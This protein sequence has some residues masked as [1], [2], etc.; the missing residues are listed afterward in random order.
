MDTPWI[1]EVTAMSKQL[2]PKRFTRYTNPVIIEHIASQYVLGTLSTRAHNRAE[3]LMLDYPQLEARINHWQQ[4]FIGLDKQTA[5]LAPK[6]AT[7][8]T[9]SAQLDQLTAET[10]SDN[11][12]QD[13][14]KPQPVAQTQQTRFD[15]VSVVKQWFSFP[16]ARLM[17]AASV[18]V[19]C[20]LSVA[21][22]TPNQQN[23]TDDPLSYVA[24][25]TDQHKQAQLVASTYG[26]SKKLIVNII[27][28][29]DIASSEDL[30]LWVVSK[31]D[32]QARSLGIIPRDI[33][34]LEQQL[35]EAQWRLIKDSDSLIVTVEDLGGSPI[36][37][38]SDII[39]SRGLCVQLKEW[40]K[41]A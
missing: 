11:I 10:V 40:K 41:N 22:L 4:S 27:N 31:T 12:K 23:G 7:W 6:A 8:Q 37:E 13:A 39:V 18:I 28:T 2:T 14:I 34:L 21:L 33:T 15:L 19:I 35:S 20:L 29:P 32:Q 26:E 30:E 9:I 3:K 5:E 17:H 16:P 38:P 24:V 36:G 25:L 1:R